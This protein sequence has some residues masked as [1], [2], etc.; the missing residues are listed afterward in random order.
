LIT[1]AAVLIEPLVIMYKHQRSVPFSFDY[2]LELAE[3]FFLIV[4]PFVAFLFWI[5]WR[6]TTKRKRGYGWMGKFEV[7][8]KRSLFTFHYLLLAPGGK[9]KIKVNQQLFDRTRV[10]DFIEI[11]RDALGSIQTVNRINNF[12]TR[13]AKAKGLRSVVQ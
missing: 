1:V 7:I 4:T 13:L 3:Y 9:N 11:R 10:G 12:S 6:E 2:Y 8:K 5:N